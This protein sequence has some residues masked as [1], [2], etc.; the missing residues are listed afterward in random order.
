[1]ST[2][3]NVVGVVACGG[4]LLGFVVMSP[5]TGPTRGDGPPEH[6][7]AKAY[8][9]SKPA[10]PLDP[11]IERALVEQRLKEELRDIEKRLA[12]Q[13]HAGL[14]G[15]LEGQ[16]AVASQAP[17]KEEQRELEKLLGQICAAVEAMK[18]QAAKTEAQLA[19]LR[20]QIDQGKKPPAPPPPAPA[21]RRSILEKRST[22]LMAEST[23]LLRE[24]Q[25]SGD[26]RSI[27][28]LLRQYARG[29]IPPAAFRDA[30]RELIT[31]MEAKL[32]RV[33][34]SQ[35]DQ[36]WKLGLEVMK[37]RRHLRELWTGIDILLIPKAVDE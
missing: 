32:D 36:F 2:S 7:E 29:V 22:D 19:N 28:E 16:K 18:A 11:N 4:L 31:S 21:P 26:W 14:K 35:N 20:E 15:I 10:P 17:R 27:A 13:I 25:F 12:Q 24:K 33:P 1:M 37:A 6:S 30:L 23:S 9:A 34:I 3:K 8:N 5:W